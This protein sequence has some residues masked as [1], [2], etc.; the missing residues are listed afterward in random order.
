MAGALNLE[1]GAQDF[2]LETKR[3]VIPGVPHAFNPSVIIWK[4]MILMTFREIPDPK[5]SFTSRLGIVIVNEE[6][7]PIGIPQFLDL[8]P[9]GVPR[10][11]PSRAEDARLIATDDKLFIVYGDN[12]DEIITR[13]GFR[14]Y[15]SELTYECGLFISK[16]IERL[17]QFEGETILKREKNW[18]PF[19]YQNELLLAYSLVP[20]R[21][22]Y[23]LAGTERCDTIAESR[24]DI[25]WCWGELRGGTPGLLIDETRYLAFFHSSIKMQ[26]DHSE[27]K[28]V[29]HYFVGA[30]TFASSPPFAITAISKEPII[31]KGFYSGENYKPYWHPVRA[32]FP[33]GFIYD[34]KFIWMAYGRQDHEAW[35]VKIDKLKLLKN[36]SSIGK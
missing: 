24:S 2:I 10:S 9:A 27:D 20:H 34:D 32:V 1:D 8:K 14:V 29:L 36:L 31:G 30:Y 16:S 15:I 26:S 4:G 23:P 19:V 21:I 7:D 28:E 12:Q 35:I 17:S 11:R 18:V 13:G 6:F 25:S 22:F 33:G 3:I 5:Q